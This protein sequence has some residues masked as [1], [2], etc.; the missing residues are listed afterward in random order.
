MNKLFLTKPCYSSTLMDIKANI[1]N[2]DFGNIFTKADKESTDI[3]V[4]AYTEHVS[5]TLSELKLEWETKLVSSIR[6]KLVELCK[7]VK[8]RT[9]KEEED[10]HNQNSKTMPLIHIHQEETLKRI[11]NILA[12]EDNKMLIDFLKLIQNMLRGRLYEAFL[13]M[14][15]E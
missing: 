5:K 14:F 9:Q 12:H 7:M 3:D 8:R 4:N 13:Q 1:Y 15:R 11:V 6:A 10:S 2:F